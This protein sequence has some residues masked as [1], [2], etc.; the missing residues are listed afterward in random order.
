MDGPA[1]DFH[2]ES[3]GDWFSDQGI[4][5]LVTLAVAVVAYILLRILAPRVVSWVVIKTK[6]GRT[7]KDRKELSHTTTQLFLWFGT[8]LILTATV[9]TVLPRFGVDLSPVGE[10]VVDWLGSHGVRIAII[11]AIAVVVHQILKRLIHK[12][13]ET[14]IY[15]RRRRISEEQRKRA[16]T[17]SHFL[18]Q[19]AVIVIW[20]IAG[21]MILSEVGV[22]IGPLLAGAGVIGIGI[23]F[24]AQ[25]LV[26]DV[27]SGLFIII[28]NQYRKGD[29]VMV[30]GIAGI[31]EEVNIRRTVLRDL[32]GIVH[33]VPNGE[34]KV[35]SNY[36]KEFSRV[37]L[38]ISVAYGE[39]LDHAIKVINRVG[40]E[41]AGEEYW[42]E[43]LLQPPQVLRVDKLGDSGIDIKI[44]GDTKPIRQWEVMGELRKRIKKAFDKEGIE[45]PWP[46]TK[47]YFGDEPKQLP[48]GVARAVGKKPKTV[49]EEGPPGK[50]PRRKTRIKV[51]P[52]EEEEGEGE[53]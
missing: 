33:V 1:Q 22:N 13:V 53:S 40:Q 28:E 25:S 8:L 23:G 32:D 6:P 35:A 47:V 11:I 26:K 36:T 50:A 41:M 18:T 9:F 16:G 51:L 38:N 48:E 45:I 2:W 24:G 52:P 20:V 34:I 49:K 17:L 43:A 12:V 39:D 14:H 3:A 44:L 7:E 42:S 4:W 5:F 15:G 19:F 37:N 31:V 29:V 30:A 10:T 46:H 27:L 21:F